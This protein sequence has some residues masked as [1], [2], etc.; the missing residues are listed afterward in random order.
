[1]KQAAQRV[2]WCLWLSVVL[3]SCGAT[4]V[5]IPPSL[6]LPK[7]VTD[8]R[9]VRK[10]DKVTL[11]WTVPAKTTEGQSVR[12]MGP[13]RICRS[14]QAPDCKTPLA[15]IPPGQLPKPTLAKPGSPNPVTPATYVDILPRE[16]QLQNPAAEITYAIEVLNTSGRSGGLSNLVQVPAA[17]TLPAPANFAAQVTAQGVLLSWSCVPS[18]GIPVTPDLRYRVRAYRRTKEATTDTPVGEADALDCSQ[19]SLLDQT[20]EWETNYTYHAAVVTIV[21]APGK[22]E[23]EVQGDDTPAINVF[24]HDIFPPAVP[25]GLQAVF[26]GVGQAPFVDLVWTPDSETDLAGYHIY[27]HEEGGSPVRIN[28]K[29]VKTPAYRDTNVVSG[30]RYFYSVSAV[31]VRGNES[32]RSEE[33]SE[34]VP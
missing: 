18:S 3:S 30:K 6:E 20:I 2:A 16:M 8:L 25:T 17:P 12:H 19:L 7:P 27:R 15:E 31:D 26:S 13:T 28:S 14:L 10:G 1:M 34:Q 4:G 24:T 29:V 23:V 32:A 9:A 11:A 21:A 22:P 5:P 33:A